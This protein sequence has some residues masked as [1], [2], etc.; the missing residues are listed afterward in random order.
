MIAARVRRMPRKAAAMF[1]AASAAMIVA[2]TCVPEAWAQDTGQAPP[3]PSNALVLV[4]EIQNLQSQMR[5]MQ[6]EIEELQHKLK[7][8]QQ[9]S[10]DQ[11]VDLDSRVGKLEHTQPAPAASAALV[12][13]ASAS[14]VPAASGTAAEPMST[15]DKAAAQVAYDAAFKSLRDGNYVDSARGFR[16]FIDKYPHSVLVSNAYYWLGGSYYVTQNYKPALAAFQTLLSKY[17]D[18]P[19]AAES[20]LRIADCQIALKDYAAAR[21][22]LQATIKANPGTALEKRARDKLQDMPTKTGAQ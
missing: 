15:A 7:L 16:A 20:Q 10:K 3:A 1:M 6:G 14:V 12:S 22:T 4:N 9:T 18:S 5:Q 8:L 13:S 2:G 17:P 19:K 21:R 11:Y